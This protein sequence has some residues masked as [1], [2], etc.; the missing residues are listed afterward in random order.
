MRVDVAVIGGGSAG[1]AAAVGA[2]R[3]GAR[4]LLAEQGGM[5][6]GNAAGALVHTL[7]GLYLLRKGDTGKPEYA[8]PGF[9]REMA[10]ALLAR[11][12]ALG[13][14]RMGRLDVLLHRPAAFAALALEMM[15]TLPSLRMFLK[16]ELKAVHTSGDG[17]VGAVVLHDGGKDFTVETAVLVDATGDAEAAALAGAEFEISPPDRLQRPAYIMGLEGVSPA[18]MGDDGR[19]AIAHALSSGVLGKRLPEGALGTSFRR[20][21]GDGDVWMTIDLQAPGFDPTS[22]NAAR[23]GL[24]AEAGELG[25]RLLAFL[26]KE[27]RGFEN[28]S[29]V[30]HP[31]RLG[32]RE[33]R[34]IRGIYR[35]TGQDVLEGRRF[36]DEAA[37]SAWPIELRETARGPRFRFPE[38]ERPC[39]IPLRSLQSGSIPNLFM[40]GRCLSA[41]HEAQA[42]LRV[43]GTSLATGE[44]AGKA[45]AAHAG[46]GRAPRT[47]ATGCLP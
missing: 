8:N 16:T 43:I 21:A 6:G 34:R 9:P 30:L 13:P 38:E 27:V 32:I 33:S 11:G 14:V 40:A 20:G 47:P 37:L 46:S 45:A 29:A 3:Q 4:V 24:F 42:A 36:P 12:G 5:P 28:A 15:E 10:E 23:G 17:N 2:A 35:L 22:R 41:T 25:N 18:A 19:L 31:E 39:G 1:L 44:A 7:C 26:R